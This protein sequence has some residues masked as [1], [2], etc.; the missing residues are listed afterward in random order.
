VLHIITILSVGG[1]EVWLL[2][3]LRHI[4]M[5]ERTGQPHESFEILMTGGQRH[6]LDEAAAALGATLHYLPFSRRRFTGFAR[7]FRT[8]LRERGYSAIHD[9]Q[10]YA[11]GWHFL[12]GVGQLPPVRIVH[13]HNPPARLRFDSRTALRRMGLRVSA[14]LVRR[15]A[16]HILGTSSQILDQYGFRR[17]EFPKQSIRTVHCGFDVNDFDESHEEANRNICDE[18][19][20]PSPTKLALFVGRLDGFDPSKPGWNHKN[21]QF[22]LE[23]ARLALGRDPS[24]RF[25]MVGGG[26]GV[27]QQL[28]AQVREWGLTDRIR[29]VGRRLDVAR[30]MAAAHTLIFPSLE[31]GLGMVAVEAQAAGLHVLASDAV[32][33]EAV[34]IPEL[35]KFLPLSAGA[36]AWSSEL[37]RQLSM[38]RYDASIAAEKV[39]RSPY[40]IEESYRR[41]HS[42]YGSANDAS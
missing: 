27:Q 21:P 38:A 32:P 17:K 42:I 31:E 33:R 22:A 30:F 11:A 25:V 29:L 18:L 28:E 34:V 39:R 2:A 37:L 5:L 4:Q 40:S 7:E 14:S 20:W 1:V 41:L 10:D 35:V 26:G 12:A 13:V 8:L 23:V 3:L 15:F 19:G 36:D 6:D 9:H 16:T 24:L